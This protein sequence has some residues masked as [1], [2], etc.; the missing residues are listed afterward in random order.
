MTYA[1]PLSQNIFLRYC[2]DA[3]SPDLPEDSFKAKK[4]WT[5][6]SELE[7]DFDVGPHMT[8]AYSRIDLISVL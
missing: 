6:S 1:V 7:A 2:F 4:C 8:A 3:I 5:D